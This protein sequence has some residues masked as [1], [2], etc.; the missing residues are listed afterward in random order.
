MLS[1]VDVTCIV[2]IIIIVAQCFKII[3]YKNELTATLQVLHETNENYMRVR[4]DRENIRE[5]LW[6][7]QMERDG[8]QFQLNTLGKNMNERM[9]MESEEDQDDCYEQIDSSKLQNRSHGQTIVEFP[10]AM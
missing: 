6:K 9:I 5:M 10:Q 8:V 1:L 3:G 4:I 2:L 7:T